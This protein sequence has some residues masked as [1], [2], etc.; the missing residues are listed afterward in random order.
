M[1]VSQILCA[2]SGKEPSYL[3]KLKV[4]IIMYKK[5]AIYLFMYTYFF[6]LPCLISLK[7]HV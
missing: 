4:N 3:K 5:L 2:S 7:I 1:R 6:S